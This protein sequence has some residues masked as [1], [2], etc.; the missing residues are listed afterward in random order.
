MR[1][2]FG[3]YFKK[4]TDIRAQKEIKVKCR[5]YMDLLF[6]KNRFSNSSLTYFG[7]DTGA[8]FFRLLHQNDASYA[9]IY[10]VIMN[11]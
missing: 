9:K 3:F 1:K 10:I 11:L 2:C 7:C 6:N 5:W 4:N 8:Y